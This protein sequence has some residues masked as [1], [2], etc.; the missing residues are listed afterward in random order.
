M[1]SCTSGPDHTCSDGF[2]YTPDLT[3]DTLG[4]TLVKEYACMCST[5]CTGDTS[6]LQVIYLKTKE[7]LNKSW[8]FGTSK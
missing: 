3:C 8:E 2:C 6:S 7:N 1:S 4:L 5:N